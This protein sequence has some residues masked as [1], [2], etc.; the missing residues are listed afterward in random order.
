MKNKVAWFLAAL[1]VALGAVVFLDFQHDFDVAGAGHEKRQD[2]QLPLGEKRMRTIRIPRGRKLPFDP[3]VFKRY[4]ASE[5]DLDDFEDELRLGEEIRLTLFDT[6]QFCLTVTR[7]MKTKSSRRAYLASSGKANGARAVIL[8]GGRGPVMLV[9]DDGTGRNYLASHQNGCFYVGELAECSPLSDCCGDESSAPIPASFA[10]KRKVSPERLSD[11]SVV[12]DVLIAQDARSV[13]YAAQLGLAGDEFSEL[14][15]QKANGVLETS[16][17]VEDFSFRLA[18]AMELGGS[19]GGDPGTVLNTAAQGAELNGIDLGETVAKAREAHG[20]DIVVVLMK[21]ETSVAGISQGLHPYDYHLGIERAYCVSD[22][23]NAMNGHTMIHEIGHLLGAGHSDEQESSKGPQLFEFS[24]GCYGDGWRSVMSYSKQGHEHRI[25][26]FSSPDICDDDRHDNV[27]TIRLTYAIVSNYRKATD[28]TPSPAKRATTAIPD[29]R[30]TVS[31]ATSAAESGATAA[32]SSSGD[33]QTAS[34]TSRKK[35]RDKTKAKKT[36]ARRKGNSTVSLQQFAS[37]VHSVASGEETVTIRAELPPGSVLNFDAEQMAEEF[38]ASHPDVVTVLTDFLPDG[39]SLE[40]RSNGVLAP[41]DGND[42]SVKRAGL[43]MKM[44]ENGMIEGSFK[45]RYKD[46]EG[47]AAVDVR[48]TGCLMDGEAAGV[49]SIEDDNCG[50]WYVTIAPEPTP[51]EAAPAETAP[52]ETAP[53]EAVPAE[54]SPGT[55]L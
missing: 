52:A 55:V 15:L 5:Y 25:G 53:A 31:N 29:A 48:V 30:Q 1:A 16:G 54:D 13:N 42:A 47:S 20:A 50:P 6:L 12:V 9:T 40:Q 8:W 44:D 10:G 26:R 36:T 27:R 32:E 33:G 11:G 21:T 18:H 35:K 37:F 17:L 4:E 49:A 45:L 3:T 2:T 19:L 51:A 7:Q 38:K 28:L 22:A 39:V 43:R 46:A 41:D 23:S 14:L 34:A 24:S